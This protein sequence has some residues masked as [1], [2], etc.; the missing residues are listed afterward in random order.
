MLYRYLIL[1][2][3]LAATPA[4]ADLAPAPDDSVTTQS[5]TAIA[6]PDTT[7]TLPLAQAVQG[8][9]VPVIVLSGP[10]LEVTNPLEF[11]APSSQT[12]RSVTSTIDKAADDPEVAAIVVKME[13]PMLNGAQA[14]ELYDHL[15]AARD[16]GKTVYAVSDGASLGQYLVMSAAN[17][18][19][20]PEVGGLGIFGVSAEMYYFK[21][22]LAKIG[23][24]AEVVNTGKFKNAMEPFTHSAM[25][26]GTR[27]QIGEVV[28]DFAEIISERVARGRDMKPEAARDALFSGPYTSL[29]AK[30]KGLVTDIAYPDEF[31]GQLEEREDLELDYE[32]R[33]IPKKKQ[34]AP[35]LFSIFSGVGGGGKGFGG[36]GD[37]VAVVYA[38]G[39]IIDGRAEEN[40][41]AQ[42]QVIASEDFLD[43]LDE[44]MED[45]NVRA[46]VLRVD[47]PGGSAIASD[48]IWNRLE[49]IQDE[50]I[51]V[52]VS[53][54]SVAASGGYYIS[55]GADKIYAQ[56]TTITGSIGVIGGRFVMG[57]LY[58]KIG[59]TKQRIAIGEHSD[60]LDETEP[61]SDAQREFIAHFLDTVYETFTSKAAEGRGL[62]QKRIKELGGGRVWT[63]VAAR[64]RKL[65]DELGG[66]DDA[67]AAARG[68]AGVDDA[69]PV[70]Y[71]PKEM[72][73]QDLINEMLSGVSAGQPT[74]A[75][76]VLRP[77]VWQEAARLI[78]SRHLT[79][80]RAALTLAGGE[81]FQVM[82]LEPMAWE[83][84]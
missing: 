81:E 54:G 67:L 76:S 78:P 49:S 30:E 42:E 29:E 50:G 59:V 3:A 11:L 10:L 43:L 73:L 82:L 80:L 24:R 60:L 5:S 33:G 15:M 71:Y 41:F 31:L 61:W 55:M 28:E 58:N 72:T 79:T 84:K 23:I 27:I 1:V 45:G 75:L 20:L 63:G 9:K 13:A 44:M 35:S 62:T 38:L 74:G 8:T 53:M 2:L 52:V 48:R 18:I 51:P 22:L 39:P 64:D 21:E 77:S 69:V 16:A 6:S 34:Q 32:Y 14:L 37:R 4:F 40:F 36:G 17:R 65:I 56:P 57:D 46:V 7:E 66:L 68:M 19:V 47:S 70:V 83:V 12:L 26:D 25:S